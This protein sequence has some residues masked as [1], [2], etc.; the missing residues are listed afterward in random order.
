MFHTRFL[1]TEEESNRE[2]D[3]MQVGL[4]EVLAIIPLQDDATTEKLAAVCSAIESFV[5]RF[6]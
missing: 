3:R 1:G 4:D 6:P 5:N 2:F